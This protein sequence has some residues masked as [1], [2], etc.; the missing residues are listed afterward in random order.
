[1]NP[2]RRIS[3]ALR[4]MRW[5]QVVLELALLILGILIALAVDGWMDD[6]RDARAERRYLELMVQELDRDLEMLDEYFDFEE[7]QV[8]DGILAYRALREGV[9]PEDREA[10]ATALTRLIAR[11]TL[12]FNG[13]TYVD[14]L[15]TGNLRLI[16]NAQLRDRIVGLYES[17]ERIMAIR[18]RNNEVFVDQ[19]YLQ[20]LLDSGLVAPRPDHNLPYMARSMARFR[21]RLGVPVDASNDRLWDLPAEAP[22]LAVLANKVWFRGFVSYAGIAQMKD[23]GENIQS[24]R[25][26]I[27]AELARR[28]P[29]RR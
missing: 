9:A 15:S 7:R 18:D 20:Y 4:G 11:R 3:E 25:E 22:D 21:D 5:A 27:T 13:S 23:V 28:W 26:E 19:M 14:L 1:M 6:R 16:R 29:E 2:V 17:N 24:L 8:E 12:R 10:V